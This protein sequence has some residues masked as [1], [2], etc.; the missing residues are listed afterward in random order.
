MSLHPKTVAKALQEHFTGDIPVMKAP[1]AHKKLMTSIK[2]QLEKSKGIIISIYYSRRDNEPD[3][4]CHFEVSDKEDGYYNSDSF[5]L[6]FNENNELMIKHFSSRAMVYQIEQIYT[7][8]DR[9]KVE[10]Q[11]KKARQL[12]REKINKLKQQAIVAKV[13][14]IA[15]EDRFE[16][17]VREYSIKLK[18]TVRIEGGKIV[19]FDIPYNKFQEVLKD[20]RSVIQDIRELQKSGISFKIRNDSGR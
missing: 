9:L 12:K 19:E 11:K 6:K 4:L 10:Y 5:T 3:K 8:I 1:I 16:F 2:S 15:K 13:K 7:F 18:L 20:L 17:S 14:E